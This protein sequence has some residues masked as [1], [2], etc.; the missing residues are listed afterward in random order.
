MGISESVVSLFVLVVV[1]EGAMPGNSGVVAFRERA[2]RPGRPWLRLADSLSVDPVADCC[3][4]VD[5]LPARPL[6][7]SIV[8]LSG[9]PFSGRVGPADGWS[10]EPGVK[11]LPVW[12]VVIAVFSDAFFRRERRRTILDCCC[13]SV[14]R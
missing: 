1:S 7:G 9:P 14:I 3:L 2:G 10:A 13:E 4:R 12:D 6:P 11:D 8:L 5:R